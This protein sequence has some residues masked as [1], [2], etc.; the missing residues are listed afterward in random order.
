M[1]GVRQT[2][3][4]QLFCNFMPEIPMGLKAVAATLYPQAN[5]LLLGPEDRETR[6]D[7]IPSQGEGNNA[8]VFLT[9]YGPTFCEGNDSLLEEQ[10]VMMYI[11]PES[12]SK[13]K[14]T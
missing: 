7:P 3:K 4:S 12:R 2:V 14:V 8:S 1:D 11:Y 5:S 13:D 6:P 10:K 9:K